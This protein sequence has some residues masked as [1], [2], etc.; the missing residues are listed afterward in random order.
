VI[1]IRTA[2][3]ADLDLIVALEATV[4]VEQA[5]SPR[6]LEAELEQVGRSREVVV[7]VDGSAVVGYAI[8]LYAGGSGD[9]PRV[10]VDPDYRRQGIARL[11]MDAVLDR[12]STLDLDQ[13]L[14]EVAADNEAGLGLYASLGFE[15]IDRRLRYYPRDRDAIVMRR[16][17][18]PDGRSRLP[19]GG[20]DY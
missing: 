18:D 12:A 5:W 4:F 20:G 6:S 14:L 11:L 19:G 17:V 2:D 8:L 9:L 15:E 3:P 10:A 13:V 7:A 1:D 16:V